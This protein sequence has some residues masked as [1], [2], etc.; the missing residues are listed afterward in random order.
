MEYQKVATKAVDYQRAA[1]NTDEWNS[2]DQELLQGCSEKCDEIQQIAAK[3][4]QDLREFSNQVLSAS[5]DVNVLS[6]SNKEISDELQRI[7]RLM[8]QLS[9]GIKSLGR[10]E[11][12]DEEQSQWLADARI[13]LV[14]L[15]EI[16]KELQESLIQTE[17]LNKSV[18][19]EAREIDDQF[20]LIPGKQKVEFCNTA[21]VLK[22][23]IEGLYLKATAGRDI[24]SSFIEKAS[25]F[26]TVIK[27]KCAEL[28]NS[29]K[30]LF[31]RSSEAC[32][33][34]EQLIDSCPSNSQS[35]GF[36]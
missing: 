6:E 5:A 21:E 15:E 22:S 10:E 25:A 29:I 32:E 12:L 14:E 26:F 8:Q 28:S 35:M 18:T 24:Q 3:S 23:N 1:N 7:E 4:A 2:V 36:N 30:S 34:A 33:Q 17:A 20:K 27:E 16:Q 31:A 9:D 13:S 11:D 19:D